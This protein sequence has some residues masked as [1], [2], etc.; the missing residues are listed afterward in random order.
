MA[1]V[2]ALERVDTDAADHAAV[3]RAGKAEHHLDDPCPLLRI[4][5]QFDGGAHDFGPPHVQRREAVPRPLQESLPTIC[6]DRRLGRPAHII[7]A[8]DIQPGIAEPRVPDR[9]RFHI[10]KTQRQRRKQRLQPR[11]LGLGQCFCGRPGRL[12]HAGRFSRSRR[13]RL[14]R[15][16]TRGAKARKD[17]KNQRPHHPHS[18]SRRRLNRG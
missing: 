15:G 1:E 14:C 10:L 5:R 7:R 2:C 18:P 11:L 13:A 9:L 16:R 4:W 8:L 12:Q 17:Q 3:R 6:A